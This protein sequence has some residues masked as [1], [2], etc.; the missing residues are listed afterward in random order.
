MIRL[1]LAITCGVVRRNWDGPRAIGEYSENE[2]TILQRLFWPKRSRFTPSLRDGSQIQGR[3]SACQRRCLASG[4]GARSGWDPIRRPPVD[5]HYPSRNPRTAR[6]WRIDRSS[7]STKSLRDATLLLGAGGTFIGY[8]TFPLRMC[9][10]HFLL[11]QPP[12]HAGCRGNGVFAF[13]TIVTLSFVEET[14]S[15][16]RHP[17]PGPIRRPWKNGPDDGSVARDPPRPSASSAVNL[18]PSGLS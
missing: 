18:R 4:A 1:D 14:S 17:R 9:E 3:I 10:S 2:T 16:P 8:E 7:H 13:P 6:P 11:H 12:S 5:D 15:P